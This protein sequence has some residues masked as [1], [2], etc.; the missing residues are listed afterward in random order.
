MAGA[1]VAPG[2]GPLAEPERLMA[3]DV[4]ARA[5]VLKV[6]PSIPQVLSNQFLRRAMAGSAVK[7]PA[8]TALQ[9]AWRQ[10]I[11]EKVPADEKVGA[12]ASKYLHSGFHLTSTVVFL[13][14]QFDLDPRGAMTRSLEQ[15]L[16][17]HLPAQ[18][19]LFY[20]DFCSYDETPMV[21]AV[22][23]SKGAAS[24]NQTQD[25]LPHHVACLEALHRVPCPKGGQQSSGGGQNAEQ[26]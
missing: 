17:Q 6:I 21:T 19:L 24:S 18:S 13:Q 1:E 26:P 9:E 25:P 23:L 5:P 12:L 11:L 20:G 7:H 22:T 4:P 10:V 14:Q 2:A 8:T 3:P 15:T 16:V